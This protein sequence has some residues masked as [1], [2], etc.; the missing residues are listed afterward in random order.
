M[1]R[2]SIVVACFLAIYFLWGSTYLAVVFGLQSIP[3]LMLMGLR[4]VAGGIIL[5]AIG[6][7]GVGDISAGAWASAVA[8]GVLFFLGCHGILAYAQQTVPSGIA[9]I[10]L[11]TIPFWIVIMEYAVPGDNRPSPWKL[12]ALLPGFAGVALVGWQN[13]SERSIGTGS[14]LL[15][16]I[17]ALSWAAGSLLSKRTSQAGSGVCISGVQLAAGGTALLLVSLGIGEF[18]DFSLRAVSATSLAAL[19]YLIV[20]G[21]VIGFAA[22]H[23]LLDNVSTTQVS[24]YTFVN[25]VVAVMLGWFFLQER[26]SLVMLLGAAMVVASVIAIWRIESASDVRSTKK[27]D[28]Q[29]LSVAA[30][31]RS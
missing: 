29:R 1:A 13:I 3:P 15:L 22:Y 23:W 8:C 4:S 17:S 31:A 24:T 30:T 18:S 20:A 9:A 11:A 5:F 6:W 26:L 10:M 16:L 27:V 25:P 2:K 28:I 19:A 14:I 7:R 12:I 21:S